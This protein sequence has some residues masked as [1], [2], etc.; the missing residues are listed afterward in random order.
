MHLA[1]EHISVTAG[2]AWL[3]ANGAAWCHR[4]NATITPAACLAN[5]CISEGKG[6]TSRCSGCNG[7]DNQ[8]EPDRAFLPPVM[9]GDPEAAESLN[10]GFAA[11]DEIINQHFE[12]PAAS[13]DFDDVEVDLDDAALL[14]L[15]PELYEGDDTYFPAFKEYQTPAPRYAVYKGRCKRCGGFVE[16]VREWH[17]DNVFHC[18]N[19]GWRVGVQYEENRLLRATGKDG[20]GY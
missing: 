15:F 18:L 7:L 20:H 12:N 9:A 4:H 16:N 10:D 14:A 5:M 2:S 3:A 6:S 1:Y 17:D 19:C 11:L 8:P 13:D